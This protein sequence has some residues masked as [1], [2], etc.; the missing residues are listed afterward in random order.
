MSHS[1]EIVKRLRED[2]FL[3]T[4]D[5]ERL[6][7][8]IADRK[9]NSQY[10]IGH[11]TLKEIE[12]LGHIPGIHKIDSLAIIFKV[13]L[14]RML[15]VFGID[16]RETEQLTLPAPQQ[17]TTLEPPELLETDVPFRLNF[18]K[19]INPR[20]TNL[21]PGKP[22]D[23]GVAP[24]AL[25]KRLQPQ[26]FTYALVGIDD[27]TMY[28]IIPAGS[29]I[30]I[31]RQQ[32][33]IAE[34]FWRTMRERPIYL[35]WHDQGYSCGYCQQDRSELLL[36]PHPASKKPVRRFKAREGTII[37]RVVHVWCSLQLPPFEPS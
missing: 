14:V 20:E 37:G 28:D 31:D 22:E 35:I 33:T 30:E 18:D 10:Y 3:N 11:A 26:R 23:W 12:D 4:G 8:A 27:D 15:L 5:I 17:Q 2:R 9:G 24:P 34:A 21:L 6:S 29:L 19:R 7:R 16:V 32:N 13:P 25:L 36:I 1:G